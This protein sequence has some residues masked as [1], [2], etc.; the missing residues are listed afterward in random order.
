MA[1]KIHYATI[2]DVANLAGTSVA[3]VSYVLN[4]TPNK[5]IQQ[6]TIDRVFA[7]AKK[8]NYTKSGIASG[9]RGK[10]QRMVYVIIPQF[11]NIYYTRVCESIENV[12]YENDII[13]VICDT[14]ENPDHERSLIESAISLRA[15]GVI[16]GPTFKG[17]ENTAALRQL[18]IPLVS[19]GREFIT[20]EDTSKVFYVGDDSFQAGF[21]SGRMLAR[22]GHK[23]IGLIDWDGYAN[24]AS[25]RR[26]GFIKATSEIAPDA[27]VL[28][29]GSMIL[30]VETGYRLTKKVF[31]R[32]SPTALFYSYHTHAQG[33]IAYLHEMDLQI[34]GDV[35]VVMV[36]TPV[37]A[38]LLG[39]PYTTVNQ[40]EEWVGDTAGKIMLSLLD[41]AHSSMLTSEYHHVCRCDLVAHNPLTDLSSTD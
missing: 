9:L 33:G 38:N 4:R 25:E 15:D 2:K 37:W 13:P 40:H 24:S 12:L 11:S 5:S 18:N 8:L 27:E 41:E 21:M 39:A 26:H 17:W 30:D 36:G 23:T 19:I 1:N 28:R 16:L 20:D 22:G 3:T 14:H 10:K 32:R 34:P 29:E 7:A 35:E 6:S 31:E